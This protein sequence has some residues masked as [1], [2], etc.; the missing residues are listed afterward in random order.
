MHARALSVTVAIVAAAVLVLS[1]PLCE[2]SATGETSSQESATGVL[3]PGVNFDTVVDEN[4]NVVGQIV[5]VG[6]TVSF[7]QTVA[8]RL[9][10]APLSESTTLDTEHYPVT[11]LGFINPPYGVVPAQVS[12]TAEGLS[13]CATVSSSVC[14]TDSVCQVFP[15]IRFV[16]GSSG[17]SVGAESGVIIGVAVFSFGLGLLSYW[18]WQCLAPCRKQ[19]CPPKGM[20]Y[21]VAKDSTIITT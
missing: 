9:V 12:I 18:L 10:C 7:N 17:Y 20:T 14:V 1:A 13:Y 6:V 16:P 8:S 4:Q 11:D 5:G 3:V 15:I 2:A 21:K 19:C